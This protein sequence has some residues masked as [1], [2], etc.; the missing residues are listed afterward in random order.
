M[1]KSEGGTNSQLVPST[2]LPLQMYLNLI[3]GKQTLLLVYTAA[4]AY[5]ITSVTEKFD[6][7]FPISL[8]SLLFKQTASDK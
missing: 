7:F 6:F 1:S 8:E 3:K 2:F 4:F 5:L